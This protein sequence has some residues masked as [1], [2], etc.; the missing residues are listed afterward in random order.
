[1]DKILHMIYHSLGICGEGHL[2]LFSF[3]T[4]GFLCFQCYI[5]QIFS[6]ARLFIK[7]IMSFG[8]LRLNKNK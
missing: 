4:N 6:N 3:L 8:N 2:D 5:L 7:Y 1:M